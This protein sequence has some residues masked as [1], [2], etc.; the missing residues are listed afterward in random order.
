M[1]N[2]ATRYK[3]SILLFSSKNLKSSPKA[4]L[5][6]ELSGDFG[7]VTVEQDRG[8]GWDTAKVWRIFLK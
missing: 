2:N 3:F 1:V 7:S 8:T 6:G 5:D 4:P